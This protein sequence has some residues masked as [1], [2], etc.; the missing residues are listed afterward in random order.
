MEGMRRELAEEVTIE[1]SYEDHCIGLINDD[2]TEVG[3]VH[4]GVVHLF[5]VGSPRVT[6]NEA[7]IVDAGFRTVQ[8]LRRQLHCMESWSRICF[9]SIF[10]DA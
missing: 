8:E 7:D 5:S 10:A 4:L 9:E 2:E 3:K 1:T 6:A